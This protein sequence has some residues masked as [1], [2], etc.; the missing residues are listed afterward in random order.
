MCAAV[1]E[2]GA[3]LKPG[4]PLKEFDPAQNEIICFLRLEEVEERIVLRW[5]WYSPENKLVKD[6]GPTDVNPE[7]KYLAVVTAY[8]KLDW[9]PDVDPAG[10]WTVAV[11]VAEDLIGRLSFNIKPGEALPGKEPSSPLI[12]FAAYPRDR[13][14]TP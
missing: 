8:D 2:S 11:Y 5:K 13:R 10:A 6:T 1:E 4:E 3:L 9:N 14:E 12:P 7:E